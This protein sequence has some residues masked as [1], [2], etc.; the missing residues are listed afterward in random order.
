MVP[1]GVLLVVVLIIQLASGIWL[2][3][4]Y[5][6]TAEG[7]FASIQYIMRDVEYGY[8]IRYMHTTA[9]LFALIYLHVQRHDVWL[10]PET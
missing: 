4:N 6:P 9:L 3:M 7:A 2:L 5:E 10:L 8:I 1:A